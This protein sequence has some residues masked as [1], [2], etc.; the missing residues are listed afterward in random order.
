[1]IL[2]QPDELRVLGKV[3]DRFVVRLVVLV[4]QDPADMTPP[5]PPVRVV[6]IAIRIGEAMMPTVM[7]RPPKSAFLRA[8]SSTKGD[9]KG[10]EPVQ[11]V[12]PVREIPMIAAGDE[13]HADGIQRDARDDVSHARGKPEHAKRS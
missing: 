6:G 1:M 12:A 9:E 7:T 10:H 13:E 11:F 3:L 5:E 8:G 4:A 2:V